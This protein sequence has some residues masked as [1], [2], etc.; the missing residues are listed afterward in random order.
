MRVAAMRRRQW[1]LPAKGTICKD[2]KL[3]EKNPE[4]RPRKRKDGTAWYVLVVWD[5]L[6]AEQVGAFGSEADA[7]RWIWENSAEWLE[8]RL[9]RLLS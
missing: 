4:M 2:M 6:P 7:R 8:A 5:N 3:P 1:K 9:E